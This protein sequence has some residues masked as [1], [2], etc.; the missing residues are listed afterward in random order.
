MV[1]LVY[2]EVHIALP[3]NKRG[4][5]VFQIFTKSVGKENAKSKNKASKH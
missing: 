4:E 1:N 2:H 5:E 3:Y